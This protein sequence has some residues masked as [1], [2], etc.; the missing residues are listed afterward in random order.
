MVNYAKKFGI[1]RETL[2]K[3]KSGDIYL[4][5]NKSVFIILVPGWSIVTRQLLP[6]A[7]ALNDKGYSVKCVNLPGHG[8]RPEDLENIKWEDWVDG[9]A[10]EIKNNREDKEVDKIIVGGVSMGGNVCLLS[11]LKESIDGIILIGTPVHLKWHWVMKIFSRITPFFKK[12]TKKVRPKNIFFNE[13]DSYQYFPT[14]NMIEVLAVIGKS[15]KLL[16]KITAPLLILQT[17]NDFFVTK[18]SPWVIY[19]NVSSKIKKINWIHTD[20]ENHVP[21]KGLEVNRTTEMIE[22]FVE[23]IDRN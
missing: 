21:Q 7:K 22:Q 17:K 15:V 3:W 13:N 19:N 9:L 4:E 2:K 20:S 16:S 11:S 6:L 12:Y 1:S 5:G 10:K 8:T 14:K 18:Y 23:I